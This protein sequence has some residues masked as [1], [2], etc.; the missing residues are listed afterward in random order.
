[1]STTAS[2]FATR[3]IHSGAAPA[4][5]QARAVPIYQSAGFPFAD[6]DAAVAHFSDGVGYGYTRIGNPTIA[7]VEHT[8]AGLEGG[9]SALLQ[10]TGQAALTTAVLGIA[11]AGDHIVASTHVYEGSRSLFLDVFARLGIETTFVEDIH[12][13]VAWRAAIRPNTKALFGESISNAANLVL[14]TRGVSAVGNEHAIPLIVDNTFATP[15]LYRPI[16]HGAS[17]VTHSA[18]K[19]LSGHGSVLGGVIVDAGNFPVSSD[20]FPHLTAAG[21]HGEPSFAERFGGN[22]RAAYTREVISGRF[23]AT[24]SPASAFSIGQGI[25]TLSV[26]VR[27]HSSAAAEVAAWLEGQPVVASVD[28]VGLP[29]HPDYERGRAGLPNGSGS[30]FTFTLHGGLAAAK[31]VINSVRTITHM[32]HLGDVR[33]LILHPAT[34]SHTH[35]STAERALLGVYDGT[36]RLSVGL[37][38]PA[39]II[40]DLHQA[41]TPLSGHA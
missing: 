38:D 23:G 22:A 34:T 20:R 31:H 41:L 16:E 5:V 24:L 28:Y 4:H 14:D 33:T 26:R 3:Q 40:A 32:T 12:N 25:E 11:G 37:E 8:I 6:F 35:A 39:D 36:L 21:R 1:M 9:S 30:V 2:G 15:Y 29:S 27:A 10:A 13:L 7:S 18:S 19:F 17:I